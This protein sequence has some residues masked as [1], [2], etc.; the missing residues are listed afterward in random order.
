MSISVA[1][2]L[3]AARAQGIE[4]LDVQLLLAHALGQSRSWVIAHADDALTPA[5]AEATEELIRRR[6][7]GQPLAYLV[8]E[9]EFRGLCLIVTP[10]VL[11]PRPDTETLVEWA[12]E[13]MREHSAPR[14]TDLGTGSGAIALALKHALPQA[15][16]H[17]SDA[18][19]AALAVACANGE[20]LGLPVQ[21]HR[22][23]WFDALPP[24]LQFDL[25]VSNPP[26]VAPGDPHLAA[27][28]HEPIGALVPEADDGDGLADIR[29]I[30]T[31]AV[32][33]LSP[34]GWLLVEHGAEQG[35]TVRRVLMEAGLSKVATRC[36]LAGRERVVAGR[37][38]G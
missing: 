17:A 25:V 1:T 28:R 5:Q 32:A 11:I 21:W 26:Y 16:V 36:D 31:G 30:A 27:L 15:E 13:L 37:R 4:R 12:I 38:A 10:D 24:A 2:L 9:R 35:E 34:G 7:N 29:R 23:S 14:I 20:R 3:Q 6:A 18:S 8:G 22:G 33:R 19:A